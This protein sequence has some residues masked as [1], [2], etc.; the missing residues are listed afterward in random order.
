MKYFL[1]II[2]ILVLSMGSTAQD[3]SQIGS[4]IDGEAVGDD[5]GISVSLSSD[6]NSVAVGAHFNDGNGSNSG[7]VRIYQLNGGNSWVQKG[8]DIDGEAAED[9][10]GYSVSLSSDGNIVAIGAHGNDGNGSMA[11]HV[12]IFQ[13][14]ETTWVQ[15]GNDIDGEAAGD[16]SGI[17]VSLSSDG[18][19]VAIGAYF[20]D[21]NG[22]MAGHVRIYQWNGGSWVQ[23]GSDFDGEA[24]DDKS[25]F[26][27]SLSSD[28][29]S[30][31]IGAPWNDGNGFAAG[32]VRMYQWNGS[33][34]LQ[35]GID[36]DGEA[37][38]DN[39][40]I[41]VS[42]GSDGN[43]VAIGASKNDGNGSDAGHVRM[44]QWNGSSWLQKGNDI[45][46]EAAIDYSGYSVSLSSDGNIVAIGAYGNDDN[47]A[48]AGHVRLYQWNGNL[49][50]KIGS[51]IDGEA[52]DDNSGNFV[53]LSS[54]GSIVAI[55]AFGNDGNG[56]NAGHARVFSVNQPTVNQPQNSVAC[57]GTSIVLYFSSLYQ[58]S[59]FIWQTNLGNGFINLINTGQYQGV[60]N[61]TLIISNIQ[62]ANYSQSYRCVVQNGSLGDTSDVFNIIPNGDILLHPND[63]FAL[64]M[65]SLYF[66]ALSSD[67]NAQYQWQ[68]DEGIGFVGI[69]NSSIY[70]GANLDT[71]YLI[72]VDTSMNNHAYRCLV[73]SCAFVDT[74]QIATLFVC[75]QIIGQPQ[76]IF[77]YIDETAIITVEN[78][79]LNATYQWQTGIGSGYQN[80]SDTGQ[81]SGSSTS[82]LQLTSVTITNN[83]QQFR[84]IS[85]S[86]YNS[87]TSQ[88]AVLYVCGEVLLEPSDQTVSIGGSANFES[89]S[90]DQIA[91]Y[92]WQL[93]QGLGFAD[94]T[95][96][97][98]YAG[99]S[100]AI[101]EIS[102]VQVSNNNDSYR[103][104]IQSGACQDTTDIAILTVLNGITD[105]ADNEINIYPNPTNNSLTLNVDVKYLGE[106]C[107]I[108]TVAG[109]VLEEFIIDSGTK[110]ISLLSFPE[111]I[112]FIRI[113][114]LYYNKIV[115]IK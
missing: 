48:N 90:S 88:V 102:N 67:E 11:G 38:G 20:N 33:S 82:S 17:S 35:K 91:F 25:G 28:G 30:V 51:D 44:Y 85:E 83:N 31:A 53:S 16:Q 12:R 39:S 87:D 37:A 99:V 101:L 105:I 41:S 81:Y 69:V 56:T 70:Q 115:K 77:R 86:C 9:V 110:T 45:D 98:Q 47:G 97:G 36:I 73:T 71:L 34:W 8:S 68:V 62:T 103:C 74:T 54:D 3:W 57:I 55:G 24:A 108:T 22:S 59:Q 63:S 79:D 84:C 60:D 49:W 113:A 2:M 112:Y 78:D 32:H 1:F 109:Q 42:L 23:K 13:W 15:K 96:G 107:I 6:G 92:Q 80:I 27:V 100:T 114:D 26:S 4:D 111:G 40:G 94:I 14:V 18:N 106:H 66:N 65:G 95:N 50:V 7:H 21:G 5:S 93:N 104:V 89:E 43:S 75:G 76:D 58:N 19:I 52:V 46:G 72:G 61:D 64:N 29:N 10:S